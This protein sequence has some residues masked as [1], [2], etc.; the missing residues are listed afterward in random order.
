MLANSLSVLRIGLVPFVL[1]SLHRDSDSPSWTSIVLLVGA[2]TTDLLDGFVA[3]RLN[4]VTR[5]GCVLDP[6]ADK[7]FVAGLAIALV[8]WRDFPPWLLF[9]QLLRDG[10]IIAVG[11]YLFKSR[12]LVP[13]ASR[14]GKYATF[15]MVLTIIAY[16]FAAPP[17]VT[18][19]LVTA[20][21]TLLVLSSLDY[22]RTFLR[23]R[24]DQADESKV[25][26]RD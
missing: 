19:T 26:V 10:A 24:S 18:A 15:C 1:L 21:A 25:S 7:L 4:Q 9:M 17:P 8:L 13:A 6:V 5:L 22:G 14:L 12:G 23:I 11:V 2:A 20:S 16:V 3:R